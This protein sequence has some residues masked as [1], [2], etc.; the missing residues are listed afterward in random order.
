MFEK[1]EKDFLLTKSGAYIFQSD[2]KKNI[3][4]INVRKQYT[5]HW[6]QNSNFTFEDP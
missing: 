6:D 5:L 3:H 2:Y 1:K 4:K